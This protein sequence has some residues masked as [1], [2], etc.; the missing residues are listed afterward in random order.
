L[1]A[2]RGRLLEVE[3][4]ALEREALISELLSQIE[5]HKD[6]SENLVLQLSELM[7]E[8]Q[9]LVESGQNQQNS[10]NRQ[11]FH[12]FLTFHVYVDINSAHSCLNNVVTFVHSSEMYAA[13]IFSVKVCRVN[14]FVVYKNDITSGS[15]SVM[16]L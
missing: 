6:K 15:K 16:V 7:A 12:C 14:K 3:A 13:C 4:L 10:L 9:R 11:V 5:Q 1:N 8:K 2:S